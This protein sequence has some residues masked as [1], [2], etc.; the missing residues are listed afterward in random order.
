MRTSC[1]LSMAPFLTDADPDS[2]LAWVDV[3]RLFN[4]GL[5]VGTLFLWRVILRRLLPPDGALSWLP[6][7]VLLL[8][9]SFSYVFYNFVRFANDALALFLGT[10]ALALYVVWIKP[11]EPSDRRQLVRYVMLGLLTGLAVTA[12]ATMLPLAGVFGLL[13]LW[14]VLVPG[15]GRTRQT[16]LVALGCLAALLL[17][18]AA[19]AGQY[20]LE[21]LARYGQL[22]GMQEAVANGRRGVGPGR[23]LAAAGDLGYGLFRNPALYNATLHLAGWSNLR[24]PDWINLGFKTALSGCFLALLTALCRGHSRRLVGMILQNA[25][26]LPLLWLCSML[27]LLFHALHSTL[28]WGFPT[29]GA[30]YG[31]A[32]LPVLFLFLLLGPALCGR[33]VAAWA[34]YTLALLGQ[35]A[36]LG[37]TYDVLLAQET[38]LADFYQGVRVAVDHH[39]LLPLDM[40]WTVALEFIVLSAVMALGL[41]RAPHWLHEPWHARLGAKEQDLEQPSV[42][43]AAGLRCRPY[44]GVYRRIPR[45]AFK[46][47][48]SDPV[49]AA[50]PAC[51][52]LCPSAR[53]ASRELSPL[54][55]PR[56]R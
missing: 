11:R 48:G 15:G 10:S 2:L 29:T 22:T 51:F 37:G 34:L 52:S 19:V 4:A 36:Y 40:R 21:C 28:R 1:R 56:L 44:N 46:T 39:A 17:G 16:R 30:W 50:R 14:R 18:Y 6:D 41:E 8:M 31:M 13:L 47:P 54:A 27:A 35:V 43:A 42:Q 20:H 33:R 12:K 25:P 49:S 3:G 7:G 5:L 26:E 24:S 53:N 32:A 9:S 23:L 38:G 55:G 45:R